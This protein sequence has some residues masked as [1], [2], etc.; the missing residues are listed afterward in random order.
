MGLMDIFNQVVGGASAEQQFDKV[1]QEVP[2]DVLASGLASAFASD[3][4]P[5]VGQLVGQLFANST[6]VQQAGMLN[7]LIAALGPGAAGAL[8]GGAL[9][10]AAGGTPQQ[11]TPEQAS[12]LSPEQVQELVHQAHQSNPGIVDELAGFYAQHSTLV[13]S[14]GGAALAIAVAKIKD[15]AS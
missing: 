14:L 11:V 7:Q 4:T 10:Q 5:P 8:A 1:A 15:H 2:K 9:E 13:K 12:K 6:G 3:Q